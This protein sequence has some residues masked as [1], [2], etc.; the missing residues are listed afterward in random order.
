[1]YGNEESIE[2]AKG[3]AGGQT[4]SQES[5]AEGGDKAC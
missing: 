3:P 1:M 5:C 4:Q 2:A